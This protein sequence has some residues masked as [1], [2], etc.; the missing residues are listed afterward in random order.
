MI[1]VYT[2][3]FIFS[4]NST[5]QN[6]ILVAISSTLRNR[7]STRLVNTEIRHNFVQLVPF[8]VKEIG[9]ASQIQSA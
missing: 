4:D 8:A 7:G 1:L 6:F 3:W 9:A 2:S 5:S